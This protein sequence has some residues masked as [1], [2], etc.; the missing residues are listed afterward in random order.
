MKNKTSNRKLEHIELCSGKNV[1]SKKKSTLF[2]C[3]DFVHKAVPE[4]NRDNIDCSVKLFGKTLQYPIVIA[5]MTGGHEKSEGINKNLA[6]AAEELCIGFGVGSQRAM[7]ENPSLAYTYKVRDV[8]PNVLLI[9]NLGAPQLKKYGPSGVEKAASEIG[10]DVFAIHLNNLQESVQP[11]GET[12]ARS[13]LK[14]ISEVAKNSKLPIIVKETG[15]GISKESAS[16]LIKTG[17]SGIDVGG[18]GGTSFAA[19]EIQRAKGKAMEELWDWGIPTAASI[20]E[21]RSVSKDIPVIATGGIRTGMDI[22]KAIAL[23]ANSAGIA[24]PLLKPAQE[25]SEK[26]VKALEKIIGELRTVMFLTG[27]KS[28]KELSS[29]KI[30]ITGELHEWSQNRKLG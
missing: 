11:E 3:V 19:V 9:G 21:V 30:V 27:S 18:S 28:I 7:L 25:S 2:E 17:I 12:N 16:E 8:A 13:F 15:A 26:V 10:A 29:R 20:M 4:I 6:K 22:A 14:S 1:V 23:G 24:L 5:G